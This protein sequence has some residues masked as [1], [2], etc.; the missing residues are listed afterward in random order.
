MSIE[1]K[2]QYTFEKVKF[3]QDNANHLV[4]S[5][6]A[7]KSDWQSN[8]P[9]LC[10]V[11]VLDISGSMS[12]SKLEY[13]KQSLMKLVDH[14][15]PQDLFSLVSFSTEARVDIAPVY[16]DQE[17]KAKIKAKIG[18]FHIEGGTNLSD[19]L[20]RAFDLLNK[21]DLPEST[22]IRVILFT[23]GQPT[24]GVTSQE[25]LVTLVEQRKTGNITLSTFGY[26]VDACQELLSA[27]SVKGNGNYAFIKNPDDALAAFGRE[28]GGLL[29]TY[30]QGIVVELTPCNG[31][32]VKEVLSDVDSTETAGVVQV[33][34]AS[35]LS[36]ETLNLVFSVN[37]AAQKQHGPR[38]VNTIGVKVTYNTL[39]SNGTVNTV[40]LE[41]KAKVQFVKPGEEQTAPTKEVDS[42]VAQAQLV[43]VQIEAEKAAKS[44][45]Y[46]DVKAMFQGLKLE[47]RGL[48]NM[49]E[50]SDH[51]EGMYASKGGYMTTEGSRRGILRAM[52]QGTS[53][54]LDEQ[55]R[56]VL[57]ANGVNLSNSAQDSFAE[58]FSE[59]KQDAVKVATPVAIVVDLPIVSVVSSS[60]PPSINPVVKST[61]S[62]RW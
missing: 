57:V 36:E 4:I 10:I 11:P 61:K 33:K 47:D 26:G 29:S 43:R 24:H 17:T 58:S 44:G 2:S 5:L 18:E 62:R 7:P 27:L 21:Q 54:S 31:H 38:Q 23:D 28:L 8:R 19:G 9:P 46:H 14:L 35:L 60:T 42:I 41:S 3:D 51:V 59:V 55:S 12:G 22:L 6:K 40:T 50:I 20:V 49:K 1:I 15:T 34:A 25:G 53:A 56:G 16:V 48:S 39:C 45:R 13:A 32:V 52:A 30:A 37:L